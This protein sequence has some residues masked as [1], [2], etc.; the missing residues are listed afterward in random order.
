MLRKTV[1]AL[2]F[3]ACSFLH[4]ADVIVETDDFRLTVGHDAKVKSL[5][6]KATGEECCGSEDEVSL[7][8]ATQDRPFN[9]EIK[10]IQPNRRTVYPAVS[11]RREGEFLIAGFEH[12]QYEA[13]VRVRTAAHYAVFEL[14]DFI[15]DRKT[16]YDY[17]KMDIPPVA[18]FR[19]LQLPVLNRRLFGN[20][21]NVS[22]DEKAAVCIAGATPH[23]DVGHEPR[24][25]HKIFYAELMHGIR[26][27]GGSAALIAAPGREAF[28]DAMDSFERDFSLP[29]GVA[30]RRGNDVNE[31]I[32]HT[33]GFAPSQIDELLGYVRKGG[34]RLM[35]FS[36]FNVVK[37]KGTW[38]LC[39]DYDWRDDYPR[40]EEDLRSMLA[41]VKAAGVKPGLHTLHTH[42]GLESRYVTPVADPRLNKT[43]RFTLLTPL[44]A[45]TNDTEIT[46]Q[47]PTADTP[48]Y[49]SSRILQF[50]GELLSYE[51]YT[52]EPPY[53]FLGVKRA[54]HK[55]RPAA[56][57]YGE[58]GGILDVSEYGAPGSCYL[59]QNSDLQDEVARKLA[60]IYKC[61][62]EY[63]YLDGSEG[64]NRPFNYHVANSQ[65]RYWK[66]LD[67]EPSF[68]ERAAKTHFGWHM[69][70]GANA[71]D[72]FAPEVF[73][74]KIAEFPCAQAPITWQDMSRVDFGWWELCVPSNGDKPS[75]G[76][77]PDM[78]EY[79][80][81]KAV[82][83]DCAASVL[84]SLKALKAHPRTE[85][86][87]AVMRRWGDARRAG[88]VTQD[89][90]LKMRDTKKEFHLIES[91]TGGCEI[92]EW[93]QIPVA[94]SKTGPVRAFL[95]EKDS[96]RHVVHWHATA[97]SGVLDLGGSHGKLQVAGQ[98]TWTTGLSRDE[99]I[100][101]FD[102]A[103]VLS[104]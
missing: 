79:A 51:S 2:S 80:V 70:G 13:K 90:K 64:V 86:I 12:R 28:L 78:W 66:L 41:K 85:D 38:R 40:G 35:T 73:K 8:T 83:W 84:M 50:G 61:G 48:M 96:R 75:I 91:G 17:L 77:Q 88:L 58:V 62:F 29:R 49:P 7:F 99:V 34:F 76:T 95:Y 72:C 63:V 94:G 47:E 46:V 57:P 59:D 82:A 21:L 19:V 37:E 10:L 103:V 104:E 102:K 1:A 67:P 101:L 20:W 5:T 97:P 44:S 39:G 33:S 98:K 71:F 32:F 92:V 25:G 27:R 31:P 9:N 65:Y 74:A 11:L 69:L 68:G 3:V 15:C 87:L 22:W 55:T 56:H 4:A 42:I 53:R 23:P 6:V 89:W 14:V 54:V 36:Y 16:T 93:E 30:S 100:S 26:L 60:R 43:R 52:T 81:S 24:K 45:D 18:S